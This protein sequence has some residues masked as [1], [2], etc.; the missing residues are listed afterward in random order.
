MIYGIEVSK[1][2]QRASKRPHK[3]D[4]IV[5]FALNAKPY[6]VLFQNSDSE[7]Q[8]HKVSEKVF[9][10]VGKSPESRTNANINANEKADRIM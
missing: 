4:R 2:T 5:L 6:V 7:K 8:R 9:C 10:T 3:N 1:H